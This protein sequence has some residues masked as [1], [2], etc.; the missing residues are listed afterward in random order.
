MPYSDVEILSRRGNGL[1]NT[2][3]EGYVLS[4]KKRNLKEKIYQYYH[5]LKGGM[6]FGR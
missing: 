6:R 3:K 4:R 5:Q 2:D 1:G